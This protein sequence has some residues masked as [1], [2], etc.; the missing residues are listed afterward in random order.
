MEKQIILASNSPRRKQLLLDAGF[1][2]EII[3]SDYEENLFSYDP[4]ITVKTFAKGKA[5][6]VFNLLIN[7]QNKVVVGADT[8]VICDGKIMGKP[9]DENEAKQIL[10]KL[11]NKTHSVATGFCIKTESQEIVDYDLTEVTFNNL[12]DKNIDKYIESGLYKGKAGAYGIQDKEYNLVKSYHGSLN[13]VIGFPTEKI[14]PIL[15]R[16]IKV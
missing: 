14:I 2:F 13:N 6:Q 8:I 9:K 12:T 16:L 3:S 7:K 11:S 5:N 4:I 15:N 1:K 10:R